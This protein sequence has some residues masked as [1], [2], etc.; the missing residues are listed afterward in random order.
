MVGIIE[1]FVYWTTVNW[2]LTANRCD[3]QTDVKA[4]MMGHATLFDKDLNLRGADIKW[5]PALSHSKLIEIEKCHHVRNWNF[6]SVHESSL[7]QRQLWNASRLREHMSTGANVRR[8]TLSE[9]SFGTQGVG[10]KKHTSTLHCYPR[11]VLRP[12]W[13]LC[14]GNLGSSNMVGGCSMNTQY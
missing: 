4:L 10:W 5:T 8:L 7:V 1:V 12:C 9:S 11:G 6:F 14:W 3:D 2:F 13:K